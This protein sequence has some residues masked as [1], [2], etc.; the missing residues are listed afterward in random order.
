[1]YRGIGLEHF[2]LSF[3]FRTLR[4]RAS[5]SSAYLDTDPHWLTGV[6][7]K[8]FAQTLDLIDD[9]AL[10]ASY[11]EYH[12]AVW[13]EVT[14]ALREIGITRMKIFLQGTRLFLY[15]EAPDTFVPERDY[16][17]YAANAKAKAWDT[18]MR[19]FQKRVPGA[20]VGEWWEPMELVVELGNEG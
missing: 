1:M 11:K 10:I 14:A 12:K 17:Q 4:L 5:A 3:S 20:K 19:G 13:P 15:Y 9:P 8:S 16:Q 2:P 6:F 7:M 18:L